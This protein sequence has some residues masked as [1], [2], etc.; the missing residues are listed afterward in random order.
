MESLI[1]DSD[2]VVAHPKLEDAMM[3]WRDNGQGEIAK[4]VGHL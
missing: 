2:A 3:T 1:F 4:K